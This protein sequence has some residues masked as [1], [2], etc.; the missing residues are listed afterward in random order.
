MDAF[1]PPN[2]DNGYGPGNHGPCANGTNA[3]PCVGYPGSGAFATTG[4]FSG[5]AKISTSGFAAKYT[6]DLG[7]VRLTAIGDYQKLTKNYAEDSDTTPQTWF[8]FFNGSNVSQESAELRLNG[9]DDKLNWTTGLAAA[10]KIHRLLNAAPLDVEDARL[11][12]QSSVHQAV[13]GPHL[14]A[15]D[16]VRFIG[17]GCGVVAERCQIPVAARRNRRIRPAAS[18]ALGRRGVQQIPRARFI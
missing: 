10:G 18:K 11:Q 9:G 2:V 1:L 16:R 7:F 13:L 4:S 17:I 8:Q 3:T 15:P 6:Q 12:P 5:Y 14:V